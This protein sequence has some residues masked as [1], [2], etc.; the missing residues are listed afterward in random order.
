MKDSEIVELYWKRA[1]QAIL[2]TMNQYGRYLY[3]I[4]YRILYSNAD[5]EECVNDTYQHAWYAMP[6]HKPQKLGPF[7]GKI[8]RNLALN[9][10]ERMTAEKRGAG[11][12]P[13]ALDE[14]S[15]VIRSGESVEA[16]VDASIL[17]DLI[18]EFLGT[19]N[20]DT[21]KIFVRRYWYMSSVKEIAEEY[22][23]SE[24]KA[25]MSLMRTREKLRE[26][27]RKE[28]YAV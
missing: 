18:N 15:E 13:A 16:N 2:E 20:A 17:Q 23:I 5:S 26:Y 25:K 28:G 1:E 14:L 3:S 24:S 8:T 27:L 19:L 21:R 11:E 6:P 9:M 22:G 12:I 10:Y 4:A 7:L